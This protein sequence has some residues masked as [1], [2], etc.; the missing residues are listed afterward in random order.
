MV[1]GA[2]CT[3]YSDYVAWWAFLNPIQVGYMKRQIFKQDFAVFFFLFGTSVTWIQFWASVPL[4]VK[5]A[6]FSSTVAVQNVAKI[7]PSS[8]STER[9]NVG[10][11]KWDN[12]I[13]IYMALS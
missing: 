7:V 8:D 12:S 1:Y 2:L 11:I 13:Y 5:K 10:L 6:F 4:S 9:E 3:F